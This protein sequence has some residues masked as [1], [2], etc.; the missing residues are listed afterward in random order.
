DTLN[1]NQ[2]EAVFHTE[3]PLLILAGAGS[4]KTRVLTHRIAYLI[5]EKGVNPWNI[6]AITFTNKAA[7]EMRERV[8]KLVSYGSESIWVSTFHSA[9][10]RILRRHIELLGYTNNFTIYD[11]DDQKT[12]VKNIMKQLNID[13]KQFKERDVITQ[14][15]HAKEKMVGPIEFAENAS[16]DFRMKTIARI[17]K[18][19]EKQLKDNNALDFDDLLVKTVRLFENNPDVL[20]NYQERFKYIMVDEYQDTNG[21][22]FRFVK[23]L[24]AKYRNLCVVGDD[25]QSIYSFRGADIRNILDFE[26][27]YPDAK[28]IK[29]EQNYR[30][31]SHILNTANSVIK[32][33][34]G[35]KSKALWTDNGEGEKVHIRELNS[36]YDEGDYV[37]SDLRN[38]INEEGGHYYDNAVLYR[39]NAQS[40]IFEE[41]FIK[42]NIP[43]K[44]FGGINF[45]ARREIKDLL[46]YFK[47]I[48]NDN[49]DLAFRRIINLPKRGIGNATIDKV[50]DYA[51][52]HEINFYD[53]LQDM[54]TFG[55]LDRA[56]SKIKGFIGLIED[57]R[58]KRSE[59]S[60]NELLDYVIENINYID[61][62]KKEGEIESQNRIENIDELR[63]KI[64]A[65]EEESMVANEEP[66]LEGL[67]ENIALVAEAD[68]V[69]DGD[70][71][72]TLMTLHSAKGLEFDRVYLVG[73]EDG[74]FPSYMSIT[75]GDLTEIEEER[76]LA[77]VGITRA[78]KELT[79]TC[80]H[81]RML[82]GQMMYNRPSRFIKE[83]D[84]DYLDT[85]ISK[86]KIEEMGNFTSSPEVQN[87][88]KTSTHYESPKKNNFGS[89]NGGKLDYS[90]GDRV[91]HF[92]FGEGTVKNIVSGG[93]DYE[94]TVDFDKVGNKIMFA[95]FAK[96]K[97]I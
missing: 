14:I 93:K 77:Y 94:V 26:L 12:L 80:A 30:S 9:C 38:Y 34:I 35:R 91:R 15:S 84:R 74:V 1:E 79:I 59:L 63:S 39:T 31:T 90:V 7:K 71:F 85:N 70:D 88:F 27:V 20:E 56:G 62:L 42:S 45:Y 46:S 17:Y 82:H 64:T 29:L 95:A 49:D 54:A 25:D 78:R 36:A 11:S 5:E 2:R 69:E 86:N 58:K 52:S 51:T 83:M 10:V 60:L 73:M 19:Y 43:Y 3:G 41:V 53:A 13:T 76:R 87:L 65:Y 37:A 75:S 47:V 89:Q 6:L 96:L 28:V 55:L 72:V 16:S 24:S 92:K 81:N 67:L 57:F 33:N 50:V 97:K 23:L 48:A 4:G 68:V 44:I 32:N 8:D 40:R 61:E 22:Q 66:T 21:V 18:A